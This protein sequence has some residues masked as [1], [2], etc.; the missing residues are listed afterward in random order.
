VGGVGAAATR[1]TEGHGWHDAG[2]MEAPL[3][4][5]DGSGGMNRWNV[6]KMRDEGTGQGGKAEQ[7]EAETR[8]AGEMEEKQ[9]YDFSTVR[10]FLDIYVITGAATFISIVPGLSNRDRSTV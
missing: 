2:G 8:T 10:G 7:T 6:G 3:I 9:K 4:E 1:R 5:R